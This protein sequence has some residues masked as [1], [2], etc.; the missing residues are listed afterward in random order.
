MVTIE[1]NDLQGIIVRGYAELPAA[2]FLLIK[3]QNASKAKIWLNKI[4]E[5]ITPGDA[6][7]TESA[8]NIAFTYQG[9]AHMG[10]NKKALETFPIELEDGMCTNHRKEMLGDYGSS[11]P[12]LWQWGGPANQ[13][14]DILLMIY[15]KDEIELNSLSQKL[16]AS[17][18][19]DGLMLIK[20]LDASNLI[21]RKEHFGFR[22]G[23]AQPTIDGL[24]RID[25]EGNTVAAGEFILGY[26][27]E[28]DQ[29]PDSPSV[30]ADLDK[31]NLL[32]THPNTNGQKNLGMNGTYLVFRQLE[33]NVES[34]WKYMEDQTDHSDST[35]N[36]QEM[37]CL[38]SKMVG[39]WPSGAPL[40]LSPNEDNAAFGERDDFGYKKTDLEGMKCPFGAH[41]RRSNP[42]DAVDRGIK[43]A[44]KIANKHRILRRGRVYGKP[45]VESLNPEEILKSKDF[46]GERGLYF[47]CVNSDFNRQ[48]EFVQNFW[49][50]NP[51]FDGLYD[52][53][54]PITGN[55]SNIYEANQTGTFSV[56]GE[57][58]R[59]RY[60]NI[61]EFV[62]VK[63]GAYFFLPGIS[64]LKFISQLN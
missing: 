36:V 30:D 10:L 26:N 31:S 40:V 39:R 50:N 43:G 59:K 52:E 9:L 13:S 16:E 58:I 35:T 63:G 34:F 8:L 54:D 6:K 24:G 62:T 7:P 23:I 22:D 4:T 42:R 37:I 15:A 61:P 27:N 44:E 14:I 55:H 53:R 47:I 19:N 28:Y 3:V 41:I 1:K 33:Q 49:I 56:Q 21:E 60:T 20:Q 38:A 29:L 46:S 32:K 2:C 25:A 12:S 17:F 57:T 51:K 64:A 18:E 11:D 45:I 48:F 5:K